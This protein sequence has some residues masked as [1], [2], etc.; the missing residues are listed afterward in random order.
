MCRHLS[1]QYILDS[2]SDEDTGKVDL[3]KFSS[4]DI[5][6]NRITSNVEE[7]YEQL[8]LQAKEIIIPNNEFGICLSKIFKSMERKSENT[9][10]ILLES[11]NHAM[12]VRLR[13]K[14]N[15]NNNTK[16]TSLVFM[17]PT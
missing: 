11:F 1:S 3:D 17:T 6:A 8:Q 2:L 16:G 13:I 15:E 9:Q 14:E 4:K 7:L 12:A 5:I 10:S